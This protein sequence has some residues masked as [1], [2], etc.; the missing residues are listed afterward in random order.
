MCLCFPNA[1][2]NRSEQEAPKLHLIWKKIVQWDAEG[3]DLWVSEWWNSFCFPQRPVRK[4]DAQV[5]MRELI[6]KLCWKIIQAW[7]NTLGWMVSQ[8]VGWCLLR[9]SSLHLPAFADKISFPTAFMQECGVV[10]ALLHV[11]CDLQCFCG[12][13]EDLRQLC[14]LNFALI[15]ST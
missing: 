9:T 4:I 14:I 6:L 11:V 5:L 8:A 3:G 10:T 7:Y 12:A 2:R 1:N 15:T 13:A